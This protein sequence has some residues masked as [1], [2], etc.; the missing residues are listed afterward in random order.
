MKI[1]LCCGDRNWTNKKLIKKWLKKK[2]PDAIVEG[3]QVSKDTSPYD[4]DAKYKRLKPWGADHLAGVVAD[5]LGIP[6]F[7]CKAN[8]EFY[9]KAAGPI[10]NGWMIKFMPVTEVLAFHNDIENSKGTKNM[11]KQAK[12]KGIPVTIVKE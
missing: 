9:K 5:E 12:K 1:I 2:K 6:H 11:I 8:W 3:G 4:P 7:Q 10:R